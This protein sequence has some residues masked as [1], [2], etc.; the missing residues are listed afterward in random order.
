MNY[1]ELYEILRREKYSETLQQLPST[2]ISDVAAFLQEQKAQPSAEDSLLLDNLGTSKKQLENSISLFKELILRRKKKLL[3]LVFVASETGIMKRDYEYML[4]FERK[5]F[6]TLTK[7]FEEGDRE[8]ARL[9][10]GD[11]QLGKAEQKQNMII[12]TQNTEQF[13][14]MGGNI[15]GPFNTGE[16]ANLDSD[17]SSLLVSS[18]K[19]RYVD[20][21]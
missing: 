20:E 11:K 17:V 15:V 21:Q 18:G 10:H 7:T 1:S 4:P 19:A 14:D 3:N 6:D 9:L 5:I 16:L 12:F 13:V 8:L 2:I